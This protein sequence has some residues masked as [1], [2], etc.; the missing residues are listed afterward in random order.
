MKQIFLVSTF[1]ELVCLA[2]GIDSGVY[3]TRV[4]PAVLRTPGEPPEREALDVSERI[5]LVSNNALVVE[6]AT[7]LVDTPGAAAL[8]TRF[9]RT[10]DLNA[11]IN[12]HHPSSWSPADSDLPMLQRLIRGTWDLGE[13][14]VELIIE[15]PQVNP[16]IALSRVFSDALIR[17]HSDG[18]MSYG[19]SRSRIPLTMGQR[20]TELIYLPLVEGLRPLL[21]REFDIHPQSLPAHT[22][23]DV[24]AE[25][26]GVLDAEVG[27]LLGD[28]DGADTA[29][30]V[31]QYL[32]ALGL[33]T[34]EEEERLHL[35]MI[36]RAAEAGCTAVVFKPHPAAPHSARAVLQAA[37]DEHGIT[38]RIIDSP[39]I[40][41][42]FLH[43]LAPRLVIGA[44]STALATARAIYAFPTA[45]VGTE[46][47][48]ERIAPYQ[49]SNRVPLTIVDRLSRTGAVPLAPAEVDRL[50]ALVEA[51]AYCMQPTIASDLRP[52]A[53]NV[54]AVYA[55]TP[56]MRYFKKRRLMKLAL[57]GGLQP[58]R[59]P[60]T[61]AKRLSGVGYR[62]AKYRFERSDRGR[63]TLRR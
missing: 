44:F 42:V 14:E 45:T 50:Q 61:I 41:E 37:A 19:P 27:A 40:A 31:G 6:Q 1:F 60:R 56:E 9:D 29:F 33:V 54:L 7:P 8:L 13:G 62:L 18:L 53:Q 17:V 30:A 49:N 25:L 23:T 11:L 59:N 28:V 16:A 3:D 15:S 10:L 24:V 36:E 35:D 32:S 43:R 38:L 51:V 39:I 58:T 52:T 46:L 22:F 47:L 48:L 20:L 26:V 5:L 34:F 63:R 55:G 57:P 2:A 21:L 4:P 12:P